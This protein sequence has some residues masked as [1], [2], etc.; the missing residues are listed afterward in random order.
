V[1]R[2][3]IRGALLAAVLLGLGLPAAAQDREGWSYQLAHDL[4]SPFC[5]GLSLSDCPSPNAAALRAW[6]IDQ[7]KAGVSKAEVERQLMARWGDQLLQAPR[8][9]GVGLVAYGIPIAATVLGAGLV[10]FV[11]R[12]RRAEAP[13]GPAAAA[14]AASTPPADDDELARVID[15]AIGD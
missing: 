4:M 9:E 14:P 5:P 11:L 1:A 12:R 3:A 6:I 15:A 13:D 10:A 2:A 8:P 7:E